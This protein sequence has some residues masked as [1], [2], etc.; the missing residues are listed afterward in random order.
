[1]V[2]VVVGGTVVVVV[3]GTVVVVVVG[4][5]V[6]VVVG[7]T[8][9]V[10]VGGTVVVVV[11]GTVV[12]VVVGGT[13]VVVVVGGT[14]VVVVGFVVVVGG[15][16]VVVV[17]GVESAGRVHFCAL[18]FAQVAMVMTTLAA[19]WLLSGARQRPDFWFCTW[20]FA[21][22]VHFCDVEVEHTTRTTRV[23]FAVAP[24]RVSM[25]LVCTRMVASE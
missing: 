15:G 13:V 2:V 17:V 4:G 16:A 3:G 22:M 24:F 9:V 23:P 20:P 12:V 18:V 7:G 11:G 21:A 19:I 25:H 5:P 6:V 1:M 8:V 14:V 10:V